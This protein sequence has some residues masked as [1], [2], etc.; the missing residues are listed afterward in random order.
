MEDQQ[1]LLY[2]ASE[3]NRKLTESHQRDEA[4]WRLLVLLTSLAQSKGQPFDHT[5]DLVD[6]FFACCDVIKSH[7]LLSQIDSLD[8]EKMV[9]RY[10]ND[11]S[12]ET[13][14][15]AFRVAIEV[16]HQGVAHGRIS[17]TEKEIR[18][19]IDNRDRRPLWSMMYCILRGLLAGDYQLFHNQELIPARYSNISQ[20]KGQNAERNWQ[21]Y[22]WSEEGMSPAKIRDRWNKDNSTEQISPGKGGC[23]NVKKTLTRIRKDMTEQPK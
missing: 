7:E 11:L 15:S 22:C 5:N 18:S 6:A 17:E 2:R 8:E 20:F 3:L 19:T 16:L 1:E 23:D 9:E 14:E 21:W 10:R 4:A 12:K 13:A